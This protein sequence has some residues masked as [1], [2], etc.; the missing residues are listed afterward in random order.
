MMKD[1]AERLNE[2]EAVNRWKEIAAWRLIVFAFAFGIVAGFLSAWF[3][4]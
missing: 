2:G 1:H 4:K 3:L